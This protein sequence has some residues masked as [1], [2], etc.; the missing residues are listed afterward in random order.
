MNSKINK[1]LKKIYDLM[2]E[3]TGSRNWWPAD[4]KFEVIIGAILT[5]FVSW[6]NVMIAIENL[7][8]ENLLSID[9]ICNVETEKLEEL[10]R[11]TRFYKQK[12][13]K[14]KEFC[15]HVKNN[16][17][18]GLDKFF[19]KDMYELRKELL[20]LYGIG[21]ETADCIILYAAEKPIFVVDTYTRRVFSK[22]GLFKEDITYKGMQK[23]FMDNLDHDVGM[24]NEYH[25]Q[26]DGIGSHYCSGKKP[27]CSDCPLDSI[28]KKCGLEK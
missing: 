19:D 28:C 10:I 4:T 24:F 13:R 3:R 23:Y 18:G 17:G 20:S 1:K 16:Y 26:I 6:K 22:L 8:K 12:A 5:Q 25:A 2:Y 15:L 7:K 14:L 9:G 21:E 11:S 27:R